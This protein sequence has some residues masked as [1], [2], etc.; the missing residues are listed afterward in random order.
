M[1]PGIRPANGWIAYFTST[2]CFWRNAARVAYRVLG[3]GNGHPVPGDDDHVLGGLEDLGR[4]VD[5]SL[6]EL[7]RRLAP[8]GRAARRLRPCV[9]KAPKRTFA[10]ERFIALL[11]RSE[12]SKPDE[13]SSAPEMMRMLLFRAKLVADAAQRSATSSGATVTTSMSAPPIGRTAITPSERP[14]AAG[15]PRAAPDTR[16]GR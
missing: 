5:R 4:V 13:P 16:R 3:L 15:R 7:A 11:I 10:N 14:I 9:P 2:P 8:A 12:R 6:V 1:C